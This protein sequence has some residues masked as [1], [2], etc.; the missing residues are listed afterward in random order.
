MRIPEKS[1]ALFQ[2]GLICAI[3]TF[4]G[5]ATAQVIVATDDSFSVQYNQPLVVDEPGILDND[6]V[7]GESAPEMG[8][9]AEL[10]IDT[11]HGTLAMNPNGFFTYS[12]GPTF[13]ELD[14]FVYAT[15]LN[16]VSD[17]ATVYL[18]ACEGGPDVFFC[19]KEGAFQAMAA[20]LGY[21]SSSQAPVPTPPAA[22][23]GGAS[24]CRHPQPS[25][26]RFT[27]CEVA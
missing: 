15:V 27:T 13:E 3:M 22:P 24:P 2:W 12:P 16:L 19:W 1:A 18:S 6:L 5:P 14:S 10:V 11:A 17:E 26:W 20:D 25:T 9:V 4:T 7:D 23:A 21:V 8:A